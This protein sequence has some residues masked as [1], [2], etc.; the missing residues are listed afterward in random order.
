MEANV[1]YWKENGYFD[2]FI[3]K[4]VVDF[5]RFDVL[6]DTEVKLEI[7]GKILN[8]EALKKNPVV[9]IGNYLID[10]LAHDGFKVLNHQLREILINFQLNKSPEDSNFVSTA[11]QKVKWTEKVVFPP[12]LYEDDDLFT[13]EQLKQEQ[14][15]REQEEGDNP[16]T[17]QLPPEFHQLMYYTNTESEYFDI[18][19]EILN[20]YRE[21]IDNFGSFLFPIGGV[22]MVEKL[23]SSFGESM[24]LI[25][26]DRGHVDISS[27]E[28]KSSPNI[29]VYGGCLSFF[30]NLHAIQRFLEKFSEKNKYQFSAFTPNESND[31][32]V[33]VYSL[34]PPSSSPSDDKF[35]LFNT[36]LSF[37]EINQF[38]PDDFYQIY[39]KV[40]Y[41]AKASTIY[42]LLRLSNNDPGIFYQYHQVLKV[43]LPK[44]QWKTCVIQEIIRVWSNYYHRV[45]AMEEDIP[46]AI[47][48]VLLACARPDEALPFFKKSLELSGSYYSTNYHIGVCYEQLKD[49]ENALKYYIDAQNAEVDVQDSDISSKI[50]QLTEIVAKIQRDK[51]ELLEK[52]QKEIEAVARANEMYEMQKTKQTEKA[53]VFAS[54]T[55]I[56]K[57]NQSTVNRN[58]MTS[59][60]TRY[61]KYEVEEETAADESDGDPE[62]LSSNEEVD[63]TTPNEDSDSDSSVYED[64]DTDD[65]LVLKL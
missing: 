26:G 21:R 34:F 4:G 37:R 52:R 22:Q 57:G 36:L 56:K 5:G 20:E 13:A 7:S 28:G 15:R 2:H 44:S 12:L 58:Y 16:N 9:I 27:F 19:N 39:K 55:S 60:F 1:K 65:P 18:Y 47:A 8:K 3:Q 61:N 64:D 31:F 48:E 40:N 62:D 6:K 38:S 24:H 11:L 32:K 17:R 63:D 45:Y 54:S 33:C 50:E 35:D 53:A 30:S 25:F 10:T 23:Q 59:R 41:N 42:S 14:K 29:S 49:L 43:R 46:Y 51:Q